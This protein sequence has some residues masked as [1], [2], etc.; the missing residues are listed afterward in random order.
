M[1]VST[2]NEMSDLKTSLKPTAPVLSRRYTKSIR[3]VRHSYPSPGVLSDGPVP[4]VDIQHSTIPA[5]LFTDAVDP[6]CVLSKLDRLAF[7]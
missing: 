5:A 6:E 7:S 2:A 4:R 3:S 1:N